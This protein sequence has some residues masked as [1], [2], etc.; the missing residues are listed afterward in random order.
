V[1]PNPVRF[2]EQLLARGAPTEPWD[3]RVRALLYTMA[4][5]GALS[6]GELFEA[7]VQPVVFSAPA[8]ADTR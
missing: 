7:L 8:P 1:I 5:Q 2:H 4:E 6:E 3:A